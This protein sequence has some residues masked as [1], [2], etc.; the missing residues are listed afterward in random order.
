VSK[1]R[2]GRVPLSF[3]NFLAKRSQVPLGFRSCDEGFWERGIPSK[4]ETLGFKMVSQIRYLGFK[5]ENYTQREFYILPYARIHPKHPQSSM[6]KKF[7]LA[8]NF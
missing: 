8:P 2:E 7:L 3:D 5:V 4:K 1:I 6:K